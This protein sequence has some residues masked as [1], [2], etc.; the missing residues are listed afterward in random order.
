MVIDRDVVTGQVGTVPLLRAG[1]PV[2][3]SYAAHLQR[4][5]IH[6]VWVSDDLGEGIAPVEALSPH[7]RRAAQAATLA[8]IDEARAAVG[9]GKYVSDRTLQSVQD[10][11]SRIAA[12]L[13]SSP[14]AALAL[15][16]LAT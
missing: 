11:A 2:A 9:R 13:V 16:D 1:T 12:D 7:T 15:L 14:A 10:V 4:A 8:A 5:G 6:A 3:P